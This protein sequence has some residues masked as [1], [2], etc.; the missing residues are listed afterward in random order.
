MQKIIRIMN[1]NR[2]K[3][4]YIIFVIIFIFMI[5]QTLNSI[6]KKEEEE[7][8][9]NYQENKTEITK[10]NNVTLDEL[11]EDKI[12][13][14]N[15]TINSTMKKFVTYCNNKQITKAYEMISDDCKEAFNFQS[16]ET[17]KNNYVDIRFKEPQEY[18]MVKWSVDGNKTMYLIK[19]YGDL[20][21]TGG[22]KAEAQE[23]YTFIKENDGYKININN[24]VYSEEKNISIQKNGILIVV[25][26]A[27]IYT[28]YQ[29]VKINITNNSGNK[30]CLLG[31]NRE[32]RNIYLENDSNTQY[33][34]MYNSQG[35]TDGVL[36][37]G[38]LG[39]YT[40][41]FN[42][43]YSANNKEKYLVFKN[44]I[45]NYDDY[46]QNKSPNIISIKINY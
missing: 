34:M 30:I 29:E 32:S 11:Q 33:S 45:L 1:Q 38:E 42:K 35:L 4:I 3:I 14:L 39:R 18:E 28:Q 7:K 36:K 26:K 15:N 24:F 17:F 8:I 12:E 37:N 46:V 16:E 2:K 6:M 19:F 40:F 9:N 23:Y 25:G 31:T 27:Y 44:I 22:D 10:G 13:D 43:A 21:A 20:L 5:I 41:K